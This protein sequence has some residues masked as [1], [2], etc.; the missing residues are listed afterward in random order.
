VTVFFIKQSEKKVCATIFRL[1]IST[2]I[3]RLRGFGYIAYGLQYIDAP[4]YTST[5]NAP[6]LMVYNQVT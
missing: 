5:F 3:L 2:Y 4:K 1:S 6:E